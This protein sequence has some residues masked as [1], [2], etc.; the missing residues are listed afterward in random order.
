MKQILSVELIDRNKGVEWRKIPMFDGY[1]FYRD[2][3][4]YSYLRRITEL[5]GYP[6]KDGYDKISL[7]DNNGKVRHFRRHRLIALAFIGESDM[8]INHKDLN[9]NNNAVENLEY[10]TNREN[11]CHRRLAEGHDVGVSWAKK[12]GKWR[13]YIQEN[14]KWQHL[15]FYDNKESAK[16][17]YIQRLMELGI[18]NKYAESKENGKAS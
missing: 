4:I 12:E 6:D 16:K 9:K 15:G 7:T 2:G 17:A 3:K 18:V 11:Q 1:A 5:K 8:P 13:A 14:N 10:V